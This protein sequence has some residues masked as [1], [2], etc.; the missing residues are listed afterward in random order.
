MAAQVRGEMGPLLLPLL[1]VAQP[2]PGLLLLMLPQLLVK[3]L[4]L[5]T[6][7]LFDELEVGGSSVSSATILFFKV[8]LHESSANWSDNRH[9]FY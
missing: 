2:P 7:S 4:L 5:L 3:L 6:L 8:V 9:N 1:A